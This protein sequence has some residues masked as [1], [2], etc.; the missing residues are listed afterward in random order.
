MNSG[1]QE[2][3]KLRSPDRVSEPD[4]RTHLFVQLDKRTG[5][6]SPRVIED[7]FQAI[8]GF[9]LNDSVPDEVLIH[10]ETAKNLYLYAWFVYRFY[11]IAEQQALASLEFAL[12]ER[13]PDFVVAE[14]KKHRMGWE[15][16]LK[17]LLG[18]AI[19]EGFVR[20]EDFSTRERWAR[21]RAERRYIYERRE[22]MRR[23]GI[24][25]LEID[26]SKAI[27]TQEDLDFD[28]LQVFLEVVPT[29]RNDYAHGSATL[30]ND[31]LN[32]FEFVSE[33]INQIYPNTKS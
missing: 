25:S 15:P 6:V 19:K 4:S 1:I 10:F 24:N 27:V 14:K 13:F 22:E 11:P 20:N 5:L 23:T 8:V 33:I 21:K 12:R 32:S 7:Q 9:V 17:Q 2:S 3:D 30:K 26:P 16:G 31:V 29:I 18:Y 28:R